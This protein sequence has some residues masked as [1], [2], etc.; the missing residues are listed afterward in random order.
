MLRPLMDRYD[1]FIVTERTAY[2]AAVGEIRCRY[3]LQVN[4]R[5]K[6][7]LLKLLV[8]ALRSLKIYWEERPDVVICTGVLAMVPLC[9]LCKAFGKKMVFIESFAKVESPTMTGKLLYRFADRFYV[10]WPEMR[11]HYPKA[12]YRGGIY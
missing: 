10:Q 3:L 6:T 4:R 11:E 5:E 9:L 7:V 12:V 1:S 8:N 2:R